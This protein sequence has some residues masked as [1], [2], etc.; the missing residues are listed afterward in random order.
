MMSHNRLVFLTSFAILAMVAVGLEVF[1][2]GPVLWRWW[3]WLPAALLAGLSGWCVYRAVIPAR[4]N[5]D[6]TR[7][8]CPAGTP[9]SMGSMTWTGC[10]GFNPGL[11][12]IMPRRHVVRRGR[13]RLVLSVGAATVAGSAPAR[14]WSAA[15]GRSALVRPRPQP[16]MRSRPLLSPRAGPWN[17][18]PIPLPGRI[19]GADCLPAS[20]ASLCGLRDIRG[21]DAVDP[22]RL[23]DLAA[24]GRQPAVQSFI[25]TR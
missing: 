4:A 11:P 14:P 2:Q 6:A 16:P 5:C 21:Y 7:R 23:V 17:M 12:A 25:P 3:L 10:G 13:F 24:I 15:D 9:D 8:R 22:A 18:S 20:L 19:I 1:L